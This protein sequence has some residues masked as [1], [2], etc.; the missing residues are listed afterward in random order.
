MRRQL[1]EP[2]YTRNCR[3]VGRIGPH[4]LLDRS[5]FWIL[6]GVCESRG[7]GPRRT[8]GSRGLSARDEGGPPHLDLPSFALS[9]WTGRISKC[10]DATLRSY[11]L[12]AAGVLL[13]CVRKWSDEVHKIPPR[14]VSSVFFSVF[15]WR[16]RSIHADFWLYSLSHVPVARDV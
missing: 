12:E 4:I 14:L 9:D 3:E 16:G 8:R 2:N 5:S 1:C 10:G 13:T 15:N 6:G 7:R 11:L